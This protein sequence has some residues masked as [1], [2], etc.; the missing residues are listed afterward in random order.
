MIFKLN[1]DKKLKKG[2]TITVKILEINKIKNIKIIN[3]YKGKIKK[4]KSKRKIKNIQIKNKISKHKILI[5]INLSSPYT[6]H[7]KIK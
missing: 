2:K 3:K 5:N 1:K 4:I 6:L 7:Y